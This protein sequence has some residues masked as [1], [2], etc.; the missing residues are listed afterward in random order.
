LCQSLLSLWEEVWDETAQKWFLPSQPGPD[1]GTAASLLT[2]GIPARGAPW[3]FAVLPLDPSTPD[4]QFVKI[5]ET[6]RRNYRH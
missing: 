1:L 6:L 2:A 3:L 4:A 5:P